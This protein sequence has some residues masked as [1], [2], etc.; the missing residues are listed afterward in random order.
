M[1]T[2]IDL[3]L[4]RARAMATVC[5]IFVLCAENQ[6]EAE[7]QATEAA[8]AK[9]RVIELGDDVDEEQM[10]LAKVI[11]AR[12]L[13][14]AEKEAGKS[15]EG[16]K[17]ELDTG[18]SFEMLPVK[19]GSFRWQGEQADDVIEATLSPFWMGKHE[20]TWEEYEP[21]MLTEIP[22]EKDGQ[23]VEF[24]RE[25]VEDDSKLLA[26]PT[27]PYHPMTY[28]MPRDG[29]PAVSMTQH[30]ANKYCQWLSYKTGHY[31]RLPTEAE[32]EYACRAG[33]TAKFSWG[34]DADKVSDYALIDG[35]VASTYEKPGQR[36]P[37]AWGLYDMHGNVLEWTLDQHVENRLK[38]FGKNKVQDPWV[39]ATKAYP[40]VT[41]GGYWKQDLE[42]IASA[43][44]HP[45]KPE[46]KASDPQSPKSIW[47]HT[48]TPWLGMRV[49]RPVAIPSVEEMYRSWNSGV[50]E[51][52]E[53]A[54][55]H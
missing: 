49:V 50:A 40:H 43:A 13:K 22:R 20:V 28:G 37:N 39:I 11:H 10:R 32:W 1:K 7:N 5:I 8:A 47:Y 23:V 44:R 27:P 25:S 35:D 26:R 14:Q 36:K 46:W 45:S 54:K 17:E 18:A 24:M 48:D 16:Y 38:H 19:G 29:H 33:S 53:M 30:A 9:L 55:Y 6:A 42:A 15:A 34:D 51:D 3:H 2:K 52:G 4:S 41:K 12:I 31:Y 21:F